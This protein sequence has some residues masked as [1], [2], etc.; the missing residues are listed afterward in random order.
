MIIGLNINSIEAKTKVDNVHGEISVNSAPVITGVAKRDVADLKDVLVIKFSFNIAYNPD[1][2]SMKIDGEVLYKTKDTNNIIKDWKENNRLEPD[3][4]VGVLN[5]IFRKCLIR[6]I[7]LSGELRLP[8]P[9]RF[10]TVAKE[11]AKEE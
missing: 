3:I 7:D 4:A 5:A 10:P 8:P 2:G 1:A 11:P 6:A 9:V